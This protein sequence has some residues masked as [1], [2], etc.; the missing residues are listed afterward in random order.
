M[1][2]AAL[3]ASLNP[4]MSRCLAFAWD[5]A[6][7]MGSGIARP[8]GIYNSPASIPSKTAVSSTTISFPDCT[9]MVGRM[10]PSSQKKAIWVCSPSAYAV[11]IGMPIESSTGILAMKD[12][13]I[14]DKPVFCTEKLPGLGSKG[15]LMLVDLSYYAL[16][17]REEAR[18]E[19][20]NSAQWTSDAVDMRLITRGDGKGLLDRPVTPASGGDTLS[21]FVILDV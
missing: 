14:L 12:G 18:F 10:L 3:S 2:S 6:V 5:Q 1:D 20:T 11:L 19:R 9:S 17:M 4:L 16:G 8:L 13:K 7:L 21:P 15:S